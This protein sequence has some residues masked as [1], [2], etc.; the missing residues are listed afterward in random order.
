MRSSLWKCRK[1]HDIAC[2]IKGSFIYFGATGF[3]ALIIFIHH[4][5]YRYR[6]P[7]P[8]FGFSKPFAHRSAPSLKYAV[9]FYNDFKI[10]SCNLLYF[11]MPR[12]HAPLFDTT[13]QRL[14]DGFRLYPARGTFSRAHKGLPSDWYPMD[15]ADVEAARLKEDWLDCFIVQCL[16]LW[17]VFYLTF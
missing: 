13:V 4:T 2:G 11:G 14:R 5:S 17:I 15:S 8:I 16:F 3:C 9:N 1:F 12:D 6:V 10:L 7:K